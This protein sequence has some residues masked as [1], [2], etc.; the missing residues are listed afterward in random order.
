MNTAR[1]GPGLAA[2]AILAAPFLAN[3]A[4]SFN[5]AAM[6]DASKAPELA[7]GS[8][9]AAVA[10][11]QVLLDRAWFSPG[12]ID[13][14]FGENMSKAVSAFQSARGLPETGRIDTHTW[15]ALKGEDDHVLTSYTVT[16]K[17]A[18][19]PFVKI[20]ADIMERVNL[21]RLGYE[22]VAEA[23]SE[24]FHTSPK[25]LRDLN[26]GKRFQAGDEIMVPDVS[27]PS[28]APV[29]A[30]MI[31]LS[32]TKRVMRA[33]DRDGK[34]LA[35]FPISVGGKRDELPVGT[36]KIVSEVKDPVF[37]YDPALMWDAKKHH[38]KAR[39]AAGPN[40]PVGVVWM[41]LSKPH[42]GLH[43]T[44]QPQLVGRRETHGCIHLTNWDAL[45][46]AALASPGL[47]LKVES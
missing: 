30:S 22:N 46:L 40:N 27:A 38:A 23:L 42:Y 1:F 18:A 45:K 14:G 24:K 26:P 12:E 17:D 11:A 2:L 34:L 3:A 6:K 36:L 37:N 28:K 31:T 33:F 29:K 20:P 8:R 47:S 13:G 15:T 43:G 4:A 32:K 39:I 19:G 7:R 41:G 10:R 44:P 21:E 9:G 25:L 5:V 16:A 35:Q